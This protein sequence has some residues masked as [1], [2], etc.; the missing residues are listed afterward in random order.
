MM[1]PRI[2][3]PSGLHPEDV[4]RLW[5]G[6]V[7]ALGSSA[8]GRLEVVA[9][10]FLK[11]E[12]DPDADGGPGGRYIWREVTVGRAWTCW[13]LERWRVW[14]DWR[15]Q[16]DQVGELTAGSD[17][18]ALWAASRMGWFAG[19][20]AHPDYIGATAVRVAVAP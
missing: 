18:E 10:D 1:Q 5:P 4:R 3:P 12:F 16:S 11:M 19:M 2:D 20:G 6:A 15:T 7:E 9:G 14:I 17:V 13:R 8:T